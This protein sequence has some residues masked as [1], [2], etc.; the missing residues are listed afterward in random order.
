[1][2]KL[3]SVLV[4]P[5]SSWQVRWIED[6]SVVYLPSEVLHLVAVWIGGA[7]PQADLLERGLLSGMKGLRNKRRVGKGRA[8]RHDLSKR[9][10]L[11]N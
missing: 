11:H 8:L 4:I 3:I 6:Q 1:M 9:V 7:D 10:D 2:G 5:I